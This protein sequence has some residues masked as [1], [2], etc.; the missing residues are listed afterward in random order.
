[1]GAS[2]TSDNQTAAPEQ[3]CRDAKVDSGRRSL[4]FDENFEYC[5]FAEIP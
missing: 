3:R 2:Q 5:G 1:M 4:E